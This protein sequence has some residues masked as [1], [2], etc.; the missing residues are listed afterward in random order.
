[1][2]LYFLLLRLIFKNLVS[3]SL[4]VFCFFVFFCFL[5][6]HPWQYRGSQDRGRIRATAASL[7]HSRSNLVIW[8]KPA[9][10]TTAHGNTGS[11]THWAR[12][13]IEPAWFLVGFVSNAPRRELL[14]VFYLSVFYLSFIVSY[15]LAPAL[16]IL[17]NHLPVFIMEGQLIYQHSD[18][19]FLKILLHL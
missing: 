1:M 7:L 5:G 6:P 3:F 11:L 9:A 4:H 8:A 2:F 13:G 19:Q 17:M 14:F 15:A 16:S 18:S 12:P 10:Y